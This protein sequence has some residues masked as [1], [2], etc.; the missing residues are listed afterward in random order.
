VV[1]RERIKYE[2]ILLNQQNQADGLPEDARRCAQSR[3]HPRPDREYARA[4][5]YDLPGAF[6]GSLNRNRV[7]LSVDCGFV[8]ADEIHYQTKPNEEN[9][10]QCHNVGHF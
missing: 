8:C 3:M 10:E 7:G 2:T 6:P 5:C 1:G 4:N 9:H